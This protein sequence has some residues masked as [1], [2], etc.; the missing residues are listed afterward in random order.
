MDNDLNEIQNQYDELT[1]IEKDHCTAIRE[2]IIKAWFDCPRGIALGVNWAAL[3]INDMCNAVK[4]EPN[5]S[6]SFIKVLEKLKDKYKTHGYCGNKGKE[7][8]EIYCNDDKTETKCIYPPAM[9]GYYTSV[10]ITGSSND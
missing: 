8:I 6:E 4:Y 3:M 7:Y 10:E 5:N 2:T 9:I 1:H